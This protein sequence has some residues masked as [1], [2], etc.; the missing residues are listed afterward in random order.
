MA[1]QFEIVFPLQAGSGAQ[2]AALAALDEIDR[3]E[4]QLSYY[5]STSEL[6]QVNREAA[7][8]P[9]RVSRRLFGLLKLAQDI[10][11]Q[12]GGAYDLT[13]TPLAACW[14]FLHRQPRLPG[15]AEIA[16]A[17]KRVGMEF[18]QLD[19][20][21]QTVR[22]T[23]PGIELNLNSV[24]KGFALDE[25]A[26]HLTRR[27][28]KNAL[29]HG[30]GSSALAL[31]TSSISHGWR[32]AVRNPATGSGTLA[33]VHLR[34]RGF[35]TSGIEEQS[36]TMAGRRYGHLLDP[37]TGA[38]AR[39]VLSVSV[40]APSATLAEMLSTAFF[41]LGAADTEAYCADHPQV[42]ALL[43]PDE[44]EG[45]AGGPMVFGFQAGELEVTN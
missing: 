35:S 36:F 6:S 9:V 4:Q 20:A 15:A 8:H 17:R 16:E 10:H 3:V 14:G 28:V 45:R 41:V 30:G 13:S 39:G 37:R 33:L 18:V 1:T 12:T 22:F 21:A 5:L 11:R 31:G 19:E 38:P 32:I 27:G 42:S 43:V 25:A 7:T 23:R 29:L 34:Q 24:G 44:G 2:T 40:T 26:M